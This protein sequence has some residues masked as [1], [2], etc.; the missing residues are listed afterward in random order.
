MFQWHV[1]ETCHGDNRFSKNNACKG[2][3]ILRLYVSLVRASF[4]VSLERYSNTLKHIST[5]S[6]QY[7]RNDLTGQAGLQ[8]KGSQSC[9]YSY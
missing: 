9:P 5:F 6:T 7:I 2:L 1:I 8:D 4:L 3:A